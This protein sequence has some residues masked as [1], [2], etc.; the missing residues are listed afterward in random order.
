MGKGERGWEGSCTDSDECSLLPN[1]PPPPPPPPP[2]SAMHSATLIHQSGRTEHIC[3]AAANCTAYLDAV[4]MWHAIAPSSA[5]R[6]AAA[7]A[8]AAQVPVL[9]E[10]EGE[11]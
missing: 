11:S 1:S 9:A 5:A 3:S 4:H 6:S 7:T 10:G 8:A 2:T